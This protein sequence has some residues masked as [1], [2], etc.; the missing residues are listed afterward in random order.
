MDILDGN[1]ETIE[2]TGLR[3]LDL[4][5]EALNLKKE[6]KNEDKKLIFF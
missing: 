1:L 3:C 4:L 5:G 6:R 2:T